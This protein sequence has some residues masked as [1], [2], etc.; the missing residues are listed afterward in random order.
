MI[1]KD[2]LDVFKNAPVSRAVM[3]N[4]IPA[5]ISI[6]MVLIY[7]L[8]DTFFIGQTHNAL[9]VAAVSLATPV[10]LIFMGLGTVFGIG[11]T[12]VIS[13]AMGEGRY[14]YA[15]KVSSFCM[16]CSVGVG[17]LLSLCIWVFMDAT[18]SWIGAS[19]D[20]WEPAKTYL[21]IICLAGPFAVV[22]TCFSNLIRAE[23]QSQ[24]AMMG[25][26]I[27]NL[28]NVVLD[29]IL[30]LLFG[31][32]IAGA[33]LATVIGNI[34]GAGYYIVYFLRGKSALSIHVKHF[35]LKHHVATGVLAIGIP[36][37]LGSFLM[38]FSNIIVNSLMS[39]YGDMAVAGIG[40][41]MKVTI[42]TGMVS[43]G[44]GQGIQPLLGFCVGANLWERFKHVLK[45]SVITS[46]AISLVLTGLAYLFIDQII[47]AF[48]Y[49]QSAHDYAVTLGCILLSTS[50][51][52]GLFFVLSSALQAM[53]AAK[54][55]LI[56]NLSRQGFIYIP[57][58][59]VLNSL[60]FANGLALA[61]P[62]A[63]VL[64][65]GLVIFL[66]Y[67]TTKRLIVNL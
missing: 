21:S 10:F 38:S 51:L 49:N 33:A 39:T 42:V 34:I 44:F 27:G 23:G 8:A 58:L 48:L 3:I 50:F 22:S 52:S 11:G 35:T 65:A 61:Q 46:L 29:P 43:I 2:R 55:A 41:A 57:A 30:I 32:G 26:L 56:I 66:Y 37:S 36:A 25:L 62:V 1:E 9:L 28:L 53:G 12:S 45:F 31:W 47:N 7:N 18:L 15:K 60:F 59:F 24:K 54:E 14:D 19:S 63:D 5:I 67:R 16:W 40:V 6:L 17:L 64:S 4:T 13:R 20:T